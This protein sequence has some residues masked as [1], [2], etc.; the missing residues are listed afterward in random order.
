MVTCTIR[1][2]STVFA[3]AVLLYAAGLRAQVVDDRPGAQRPYPI[4]DSKLAL[5]DGRPLPELPVSLVG[6]WQGDDMRLFQW[7]A[8]LAMSGDAFVGKITLPDFPITVPLTVQGTRKGDIVEFSVR[9]S[10]A[11]VAYFGGHVAGT[12]LVGTFENVRGEQKTW[13]AMWLPESLRLEEEQVE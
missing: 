2:G 5:P 7:Q 9:V 8:D 10:D 12:S 1:W 6:E 4:D 3:A 13:N 11:E